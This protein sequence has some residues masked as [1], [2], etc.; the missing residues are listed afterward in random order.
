M[1]D[2]AERVDASLLWRKEEKRML[3]EDILFTVAKGFSLLIYI[4]TSMFSKTK[5]DIDDI[6]KSIYMSPDEHAKSDEKSTE[7][8]KRAE[9]EQEREKMR[10]RREKRKQ[11]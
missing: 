8:E 4:V 9:I 1:Y 3:T 7:E 2:Y 10:K 11:Q 6:R 5:L